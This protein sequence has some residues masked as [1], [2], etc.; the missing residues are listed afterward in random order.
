MKKKIL[1]L[2]IL[3]TFLV[4]QSPVLAAGAVLNKLTEKDVTSLKYKPNAVNVSYAFVF[5]G[6]SDKNNQVMEQF[7][8][9][10]TISNAPDFKSQFAKENVYVGDWTTAGVKKASDRALSSNARVVISLG[11]L[12]SKYYN[13]MKSK[14]KTVITIDQYGL[15][16]LGD[17]FF[18]HIQQTASGI[19]LFKRLVEFKRPVLLMNKSF[20]AL[21][22]D[23]KSVAKQKLPDVDLTI[24]PVD[25]S[26]IDSVVESIKANHD[27]VIITPIYNLT[28]EN[29]QKLINDIN[30]AKVPTFSTLGKE[31]VEAG[32]LLGTGALDLDRKIAEMTSFSIKGILNGDKSIP[33]KINFFEDQMVYINQDTADAIGWAPHLRVLNNAEIISKKEVPVYSL[34]DVFNALNA[35][36]LDIERKRALVSAARRSAVAAALRYLPSFNVTLGYQQYNEDYAESAKILY[37]EKTGVFSMGV[38]QI[39]Y[40]P[41]LVTNILLKKKKL[42]FSKQELFLEE[43]NM[44]IDVA[45]LYIETLMLENMMQVQH[46]YV[47]ESRENLAIARVREKM[48]KCGQEESLRWAAQLNINE[49]NLL[50]MK[51]AVK[52]VKIGINKILF[53]DQ[54]EVYNLKPLKATDP[55]FYTSELNI[56]NYVADPEGLEGFI[57]LVIEEAYRVAPELAKLKMAQKMKSYEAA[58][59]YQKF[60]LPDA[61]LVLEYQSLINRQYTSPTTLPVIDQRTGGFFTMPGA[62]ATHGYFGIFAQ[63]KPIEGG[64]KIAEIARIKAEQRELKLYETEVKTLLEQKVRDIFNKALA[65]YFSIEKNYKASYAAGENYNMVKV[66]Y[67]HGEADVVQ[68]LDAQKVYL[69]AKTAALNSQYAFFKQLIWLQRSICAVDWTNA[70]PDA[71]KFIQKVKDTL[72]PVHDIEWI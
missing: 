19:M 63:W 56:L 44:G 50:D 4:V 40:S 7:K 65:A 37:P 21:S 24:L 12:S 8:K 64:T 72:R 28:A 52:N 62:D 30:T 38:E 3:M 36:N 2:F 47:Q 9:A 68:L 13:D 61:K 67:L 69:D 54:T 27:A 20:Y 18:N 23:W 48:G 60:I 16:D 35:N 66:R 15:R 59:Y 1:S 25:N 17:G 43:Q 10:I 29:K 53:K 22:K 70:S 33:T 49:K 57:K 5:D 34:S 46:D 58:M 45:L 31:D 42:D 71:K 32:V 6:P 41:A 26:N 11:Y 14:N 55:A 51:A 39:I